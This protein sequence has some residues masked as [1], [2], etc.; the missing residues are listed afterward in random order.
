MIEV[1]GDGFDKRDW[2]EALGLAEDDLV[3][4]VNPMTVGQSALR[5]SLLPA[6]LEIVDYNLRQGVDGGM[7]YELGRIFSRVDGECDALGGALFGR[8]G[9]P[10]QGKEMVSLPIAKGVL[11]GLFR[12]LR[13]DAITTTP[14]DLPP[15][16]HTGRGARFLRNGEELGH[17]GELAPELVDRFAL[18]TSVLVFSFNVL[19]LA[20]NAETSVRYTPLPQL[21]ASKRD[22]SVSAPQGLA[23]ETVRAAIADAREVESI[24]LYDVYRGE[25]V[26]DGRVSLTY[27]L[28]F[29]S[30]E[31]TLTDADVDAVVGGID[32]RLKALDVH[33]RS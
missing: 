30:A 29:R 19:R 14:E 22:L 10:L 26:G 16:L 7:I 6:V 17:L 11:D 3:T 31:R 9:I 18:P 13:L 23:E 28:V 27:E 12:A 2:R 25:Q 21:P 20:A 32:Q 8:T 24:L 5:S 4:T 15:Y 1:V 33:I